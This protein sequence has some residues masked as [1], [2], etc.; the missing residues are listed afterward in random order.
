LTD[1]FLDSVYGRALASSW[2]DDRKPELPALDVKD[3]D[4]AGDLDQADSGGNDDRCPR[5]GGQILQ[6]VRRGK[7]ARADGS[8]SRACRTPLGQVPRGSRRF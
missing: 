3:P 7:G 4:K 8:A 1:N 2:R 6:Q 5:S